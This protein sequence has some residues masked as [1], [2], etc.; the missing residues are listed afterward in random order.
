M[1]VY[2]DVSLPSQ[3]ECDG[4]SVAGLGVHHVFLF[5]LLSLL[6]LFRCLVSKDQSHAGRL[7]SFLL[8]VGLSPCLWTVLCPGSLKELCLV[9]PGFLATDLWL[10]E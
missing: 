10:S 7:C 9:G 5:C 1:L 4:V 3:V 2:A 8:P 6:F